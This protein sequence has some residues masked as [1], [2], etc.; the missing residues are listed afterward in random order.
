MNTAVLVKDYSE[1]GP[2]QIRGLPHRP[3][4]TGV[5]MSSEARVGNRLYV[6]DFQNSTIRV[7]N[8]EWVDITASVPFARPEGLPPAFSPYDI[9]L[10]GG[11]LYVTFAALN[12]D[13]DEAAASTPGPGTGHVAAYDL[14]G[15]ILQEFADAGRLNAPWGLAI[16]PRAFGA[17][18]GALLVGN[19][20][21]GDEGG[22]IAAFD[23][24]H[25]SVPGLLARRFRETDQH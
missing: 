21:D 13:A 6:A 19:F 15:R 22:T 24:E 17:F 8:H 10:L 18:G 2:D 7:L 5:A 25:G 3:A 14:D 1:H 12:T 11:R 23:V 4:F 16:A 9:Q 20:G